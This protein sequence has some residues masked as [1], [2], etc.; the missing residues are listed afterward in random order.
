[1][2]TTITLLTFIQ[3]TKKEKEK[4]KVFLPSRWSGAT[5]DWSLVE[6]VWLNPEKPTFIQAKQKVQK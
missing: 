2:S 4:D 3:S 5:R 1:M 6:E